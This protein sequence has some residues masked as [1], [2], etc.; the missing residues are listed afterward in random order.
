MN[1]RYLNQPL[2]VHRAVTSNN[3]ATSAQHNPFLMA[4]S[5][6]CVLPKKAGVRRPASLPWLIGQTISPTSLPKEKGQFQDLTKREPTSTL[7]FRP[8]QN[9]PETL[10]QPSTS[11]K[12]NLNP[13]KVA[14]CGVHLP[15]GP[16]E[17]PSS[18][19]FR[20]HGPRGKQV[21]AVL[22]G[23]PLP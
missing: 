3:L 6:A 15:P 14:S 23:R 2:R 4:P 7:N 11:P 12:P 21:P 10:N 20:G 13:T 8:S 19:P 16:N 1:T 9:Q 22:A 5:C 17:A 18:R